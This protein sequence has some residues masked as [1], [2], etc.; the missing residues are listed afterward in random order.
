M[1]KKKRTK[2]KVKEKKLF[3]RDKLI[4]K[5][6]NKCK[7]C[8]VLLMGQKCHLLDV[9][10]SKRYFSAENLIKKKLQ[11]TKKKPLHK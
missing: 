5:M 7:K 4:C 2:I 1:K 6:I 9:A 8:K 3:S 10:F 11:I